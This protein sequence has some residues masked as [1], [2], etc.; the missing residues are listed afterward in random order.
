MSDKCSIP[1]LL[2]KDGYPLYKKKVEVWEVLTTLEKPKQALQ[3]AINIKC[4]TISAEVFARLEIAQLNVEGGV[5]VLTDELDKFCLANS[6][7][8]VFSAIE[9]LESFKRSENMTIVDY[10]DEFTRLK[11]LVTEYM[12]TVT[13]GG[14]KECSDSILAYRIMKHANLIE[15]E[16]L[17][18]RAHVKVLSTDE[19]VEVLKRIYGER[20]VKT[21]STTGTRNSITYD[22][23]MKI[24]E[25]MHDA[26]EDCFYSRHSNSSRGRGYHRGNNRGSYSN[27]N[28][29]G[30]YYKNHNNYN[31]NNRQKNPNQR[32]GEVSKC[33]IC[34]SEWHWKRDC[35]KKNE[36]YLLRDFTTLLKHD[37]EESDEDLFFSVTQANKAL[38]DTGAPSTVCG[39]EW[40]SV[41]VESLT[42]AER[43]EITEVANQ[44]TFRFGDGKSVVSN[45]VKTIPIRLCGRDMLL[46]T[47]VI[48]NSIPL[49]LSGE[50]MEKM[51]CIIN[52][53]RMKFIIGEDEQELIKTDS[54]HVAVA[55]GRG[56]LLEDCKQDSCRD[57][58][59]IFM[60][61][62]SDKSSKERAAHLHRYFAHA[63]SGK[64]GDVVKKSI[65]PDKKE[66]LEELIKIDKSCTVCLKH[67]KESPRKRVALPQGKTFNDVVAMDLK[68]LEDKSLIL[69]VIDTLS[70]YSGVISVKSKEAREIVDKLFQIWISIFGRPNKFISD[71]GG[72]FINDEFN[73]MCEH[74]DIRLQTSP[75][76]SPWCQG[77]VERHNAIIGQ[78]IDK[79]MMSTG[80]TRNIAICWAMNAKNTLSNIY[81]FSP[82]FLVF[83]RNPS[84][85]DVL[86]SDSLTTLNS[87]SSSKVVADHL[88]AM[89]EARRTFV[90]LQN[91][92]K[93]KRALREKVYPSSTAKFVP[94][95][96]VYWKREGENFRGPATVVGQ[97]N[98]QVLIWNYGRVVKINPNRVKLV[99]KADVP[100][101]LAGVIRV[102]EPVMEPG[103]RTRSTTETAAVAVSGPVEEDCL[104]GEP[105]EDKDPV[106]QGVRDPMDRGNDQDKD[107]EDR[108]SAR[109]PI[110]RGVPDS[111]DRREDKDPEDRGTDKDPS[112][113]EE[114]GDMEV[115]DLG[116]HDSRGSHSQDQLV[117]Q[118]QLESLSSNSFKTHT[119]AWSSVSSKDSGGQ[120]VDLIV[121]DVIRFRLN[122]TDVWERAVVTQRTGKTRTTQNTFNVDQEE[123]DS[124]INCD[125]LYVEKLTE[126]LAEA[127]SKQFG[128]Q[129]TAETGE[130]EDVDFFSGNEAEE[131][132]YLVGVPE[133]AELKEAKAEEL[134]RFIKFGAYKE[135]KDRGQ[136]AVSSR[137]VV[138]R[139]GKKMKVRL[140]A[141]GFE[142]LKSNVSDAPTAAAASKRIFLML[143]ASF[144]WKI[145]SVDITA[146]FLQAKVM[147][148][149]VFIRPPA[150]IRLPGVLWQLYKPM[151]GLEDSSRQWYFTLKD[152]LQDLGCVV[153]KL[154]KSVFRYYLD[155]KLQ[156]L[157][158]THVDDIMYSGTG[159][160]RLFVIKKLTEKFKISREASG[161]FEYLGWNIVQEL[162]HIHVD[163]R[164]YAKSVNAVNLTSERKM[165]LDDDLSI[166]EVKYYQKLLGK[167]LW[168][169]CQTRPDLSFDT[170]EHSTYNKK[171]TVRN[172]MS[173]NKVVKK[174][175]DGPKH[176]RFNKIDINRE[177]LKIVFYADASLGNL[178]K[179]KT[180]SGRGYVIFLSNDEGTCGVMDYSAN[181]VKRKVKSILGAETLAYQDAMS[182]A[183]YVRALISEIIYRDADSHI[184]NIVGV[185]DSKQL[186]ESIKSTKQCLEHRLRMDM[187]VIQESMQTGDVKMLW[188]TTQG[189]LS[190]CMTKMSADCKP[191]C[192]AVETGD[193]SQYVF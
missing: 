144:G 37:I 49:L 96:E 93:L 52:L 29:R 78:M 145:E 143:T 138:G 94:G 60:L 47:H 132:M 128:D 180:D 24:K 51:K 97:K 140:V 27:N 146:A 1:F 152:T 26:S 171:P 155:N 80:C 56:E 16:E 120:K 179:D 188:T 41:F 119:E 161:I 74:L 102:E 184:I 110:D 34:Q 70:R 147:M 4:P 6:V 153:S 59:R 19:M 5:K 76:E 177:G 170:M 100:D 85:P 68:Q 103:P 162:D 64:L 7:E 127:V 84:V 182:A 58:Q 65:L 40:F 79:V 183:I 126:T 17:M 112:N 8:G 57:C 124:R 89:W 101:Q 116:S 173:L 75:S 121:G 106:V 38:L 32:N 139:K 31:S 95:D 135:V 137:W 3:L 158:V 36:T 2:K 174:L 118:N 45:V 156:G 62:P 50:S 164:S 117:A 55:I 172:L 136:F 107:P 21:A 63:S 134:R 98:N 83:G 185:T 159:K 54:G 125:K 191:L 39:E 104:C 108:E 190:D 90:E 167:L 14:K 133:S 192:T 178:G 176:L 10:I 113:G 23:T 193:I 160:F 13:G 11:R 130:D 129:E 111:I 53:S 43:H 35:P 169:S 149:N 150:D 151:Y 141:R 123:G 114:P 42:P 46:K 163:Q 122:D 48:K 154:D 92:D 87:L 72:E 175:P 166:D 61:L 168:L 88:N 82:H 9:K 25:E 67:K 105:S 69:H 12:P 15:S 131:T 181:K 33:G 81:G 109:D 71:N 115:I 28:Y 148:R 91:S 187:A 142:E 165:Q 30:N 18:V 157:L 22:P 77:I 66:I 99:L 186:H 44:K 86:N 189:Q 73:S 20:R